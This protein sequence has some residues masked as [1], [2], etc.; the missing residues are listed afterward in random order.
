MPRYLKCGDCATRAD[1]LRDG[2]RR[3]QPAI[4]F[5]CDALHYIRL[6]RLLDAID[7]HAVAFQAAFG[8]DGADEGDE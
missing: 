6:P 8:Y 5:D 7:A 4:L 3:L 2:R 1:R